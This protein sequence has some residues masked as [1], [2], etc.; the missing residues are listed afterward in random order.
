MSNTRLVLTNRAIG[1]TLK[2]GTGG[3]APALDEVSPYTMAKALT[4]DRWMPWQATPGASPIQFDIDLGSA[5]AVTC[6]GVHGFRSSAFAMGASTVNVMYATAYPGGPWTS[7]ETFSMISGPRDSG[8]TF[9]SQS[10]RYWRFEIDHGGSSFTIGKFLLGVIT[11]LGAIHSPGGEQTPFRNRL[12]SAM[13]SGVIVANDLGDPGMDFTLPF[14][15]VTAAKRTTLQGMHLAT[16][17]FSLFDAD[18]GLYEVILRN[19]RVPTR[20]VYLFD[21]DAELT[22]LP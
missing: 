21:V 15:L 11:D 17:S 13:P 10:K 22:R 4:A 7:A 14:G 9:A 3:G 6:A 2:N 8:K 18:D 20:R 1:A 12:E 19:G 16:G 5:L